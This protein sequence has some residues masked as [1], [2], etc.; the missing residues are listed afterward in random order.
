LAGDPGAAG[1]LPHHDDQ[2]LEPVPVSAEARARSR[3]RGAAAG[4]DHP[5]AAGPKGAA[6]PPRLF[7][8][9]RQIWRAAPGR[10]ARLALGCTRLLPRGAAQSSLPTLSRAAQRRVLAER[11]HAGD[12]VDG[13]PAQHRLRVH[14]AV[15][16]PT[17]AEEHRDPRHRNGDDR[18]HPGARH[19][20]CHDTQGD[21][22][23]PPARLPRH[24]AGRGP[25]HRAR[26]RPVPELHAAALR[27]LRHAV[28]PAAGVPHHQ[29][30]FGLP[31]IAGGVR[32]HPSR[33]RGS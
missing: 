22:R 24:R 19:R 25:R 15:V 13:H 11:D 27:A 5:A 33:T 8:D 28:D 17:R 23:P 2:D 1:R 6:R 16:D 30:A 9:R 31:A 18:H 21:R 29:S 14:R 12:A 10:V 26:R 4:A 7:G 32:D 3:R 20:L